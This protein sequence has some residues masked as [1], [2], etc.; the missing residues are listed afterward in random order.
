MDRE[1]VLAKLRANAS[2]LQAAGVVHVRL[3]GS[4]AR[5]AISPASD[6]DLVAELDPARRLTLLD[7][8]GLELRLSDLLGAKVDLSP[9]HMLKAPV[10]ERADREAVLAF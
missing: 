7:M 3:H 2:E 10:R 4:L 9:A 5:G 6:I 8:V 1:L